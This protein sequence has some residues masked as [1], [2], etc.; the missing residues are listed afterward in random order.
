MEK[1]GIALKTE[2]SVNLAASVFGVVPDGVDGTLH[3]VKP[4]AKASMTAPSNEPKL[5]QQA[6]KQAVAREY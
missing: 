2:S 5:L 6:R 4:L 1:L 3:K